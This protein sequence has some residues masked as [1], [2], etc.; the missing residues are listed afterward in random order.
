MSG[1]GGGVEEPAQTQLVQER[2]LG[3]GQFLH[4]AKGTVVY[5]RDADELERAR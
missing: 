1:V 3:F 2:P 5:V 4:L